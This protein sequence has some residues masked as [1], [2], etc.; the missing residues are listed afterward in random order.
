M[1]KKSMIKMST[2]RSIYYLL[3][4]LVGLLASF[5]ITWEKVEL[6]KDPKHVTSCSINPLL[7]CQNVMQ[8][9]EASVFGFPN[10]LLGIIGFS[11][12]FAFGFIALFI[13]KFPPV[14]YIFLV[15]GLGFAVAFSTW[16]FSQAT[17]HIGAI[18]LYC[19]AVWLCSY[20]MFFD[21]L[22]LLISKKLG[23]DDIAGW[24][25]LVGLTGWLILISI[26]LVRYWDQFMF[27]LQ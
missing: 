8:S 26:I 7:S 25:W 4:S 14:I 22:A 10:P 15:S 17:F 11:M 13:K 12:I 18:C 5:I 1:S 16:L 20:M 27:M 19:V 21:V 6:L 24:G 2:G 9:D 3:F 23:K